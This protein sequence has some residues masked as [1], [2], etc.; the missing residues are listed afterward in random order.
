MILKKAFCFEYI[1]SFVV[2]IGFGKMIDVHDAWLAFLP[3]TMALNVL[4]FALGFLIIGFW[5]CTGESLHASN[6]SDGYISKG[7]VRDSEQTI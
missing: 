5:N 4:Y 3:N 6:Y 1:F 2:G 7:Y